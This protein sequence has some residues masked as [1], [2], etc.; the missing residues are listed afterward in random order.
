MSHTGLG[1]T[2]R[3]LTHG[4][5][6]QTA[7]IVTSNNSDL[8]TA[9]AA[10][11]II[12]HTIT[13]HNPALDTKHTP[14]SVGDTLWD[15]ALADPDTA[16]FLETHQLMEADKNMG[17]CFVSQ[18]WLD[19]EQATFIADTKAFR[20]IGTLDTHDIWQASIP[21]ADPNAH[22]TPANGNR[23]TIALALRDE[24]RKY[25]DQFDKHTLWDCVGTKPW[26]M[27]IGA[28]RGQPKVHKAPAD[29][30]P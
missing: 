16:V 26:Q 3:P 15:T 14:R 1:Y 22:P 9:S 25:I 8:L 5:S 28:I 20:S 2:R 13:P 23:A 18:R 27:D 30:A 24:Y 19:A 11:R 17:P 7:T 6:H 21:A 29:S 10:A 12:A 4:P